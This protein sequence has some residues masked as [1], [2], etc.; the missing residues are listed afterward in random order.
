MSDEIDCD[1]EDYDAI[2]AVAGAEGVTSGDV[3]ENHPEDE[4]AGADGRKKSSTSS[5]EFK[6]DPDNPDKTK[7]GPT[8][9]PSPNVPKPAEQLDQPRKTAKSFDLVMDI[10]LL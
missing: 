4:D 3:V 8:P 6:G 2:V 1:Y 5:D 10:E 9:A 7:T